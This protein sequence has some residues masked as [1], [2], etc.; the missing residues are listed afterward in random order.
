[1]MIRWKMTFALS[2]LLFN[3][4]GNFAFASRSIPVD[5]FRCANPD[6]VRGTVCEGAVST[7]PL[8]VAV[9]IPPG[10]VPTEKAEIT[11]FLHGHNY[12]PTSTLDQIL[13]RFSILEHVASTGRNRIAVFPH[14]LNKCDEFK[15]QLA[16]TKKL[17]PF[18]ESIARWMVEKQLSKT[19]E[20]GSIALAGQ[21]GA[22]APLAIIVDQ[23]L[24]RDHIRELY[25]LDAM[26]GNA[27]SFARFALNPK[28]R[29]WSNY[30]PSSSTRQQNELVMKTLQQSGISF[31]TKSGNLSREEAASARVGFIEANTSHAGAIRYLAAFMGSVAF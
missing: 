10:Y 21:S 24:Y 30:L 2:I 16:P 5:H 15:T 11:L 13:K 1:M 12:G 20:I 28:N 25:L 18:I 6:P 26:Y 22:Y 9:Q 3:T 19:A 4:V 23:D 31:F 29:F 14:S 7:Y 27:A 17:K 8:A